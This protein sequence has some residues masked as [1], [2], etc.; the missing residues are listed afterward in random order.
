MTSTPVCGGGG[1]YRCEVGVGVGIEDNSCLG[2]RKWGGG[3]GV[4]EGAEWGRAGLR[5][6]GGITGPANSKGGGGGEGGGGEALPSWGGGS[7]G[8]DGMPAAG[9]VRDVHGG[10]LTLLSSPM[11]HRRLPQKTCTP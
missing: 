11:I 4:Y 5:V 6:Q 3:G 1:Q 8:G 10:R 7:A 9:S 2:R